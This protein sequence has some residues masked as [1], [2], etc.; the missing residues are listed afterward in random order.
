MIT[1]H[2]LF[3]DMR[4]SEYGD[5]KIRAVQTKVDMISKEQFR[6]S[7]NEEIHDYVFAELEV[8]PISF[9]IDNKTMTEPKEIKMRVLNEWRNQEV[10]I[11]GTEFTISIP[12]T[13]NPDLWALRPQTFTTNPPR[14]TVQKTYREELGG[15]LRIT[16]EFRQGE[17]NDG[18]LVT[19]EINSNNQMIIKYLEWINAGVK[20]LNEN[21]H[22]T[23]D[24]VINHRRE[25]VGK[26]AA[27]FETIGI[28]LKSNPNAPSMKP[29][30]LER[31]KP[32]ELRTVPP[33]EIEHN[34]TDG[35]YE[36]ILSIIKHQGISFEQTPSTFNVHDEVE[37]RDMLLAN[38]NT[39]YPGDAT[40]E[41]FRKTGKTDIRIEF[42][43]RA[44]F[45]GECKIWRGDQEFIDAIDQ[46]TNYTTWRDCK[47]ALI[48]FNKHNVG[49]SK[50][51][52]KIEPLVSSHQNFVRM[53]SGVNAGEW[54][55][56]VKS[57]TDEDRLLTIHVFCFDLY[58]KPQD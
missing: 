30:K 47:T 35:E 26:Q 36:N 15:E 5:G 44:A 42:E 8:I 6:N 4:F 43:N 2:L 22:T 29:L 18:N 1:D 53:E 51:Q 38:L 12:F 21:L 10:L 32:P 31:R 16:F 20:T 17:L 48:I 57:D 13:G 37:L 46:L 28:P 58:V 3:N 11:D 27:I 33:K 24:E 23:I 56:V 49:F 55:F 50:I 54:R 34:I 7:T 41:T 25:R 45:V 14:G 19:Q 52:E 9:Y 39:H 40:G